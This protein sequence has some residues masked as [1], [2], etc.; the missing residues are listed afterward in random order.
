MKPA[1]PRGARDRGQTEA[2]IVAAVGKVLARDGFAGLGVNAVAREAGVDK[3]LIY[4]YFGGLPELIRA[5]GASGSFW[6]PVRELMGEDPEA[7][8]E[9]PLAE[10]YAGFMENLIDALRARPLTLEILA[11]ELIERKALSGILE[12]ER[13]AWGAQARQVLGGKAFARRHAFHGMTLLL[14]G[15]IQYLLLRSRGTRF[16][17]GVDVRSDKGWAR[18][19]ASVREAAM[20]LLG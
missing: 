18:L 5:W 11:A 17:D 15:G 9:L 16:F 8:L 2:R 1:T 6:P 13:E 7:F 4:R 12:A 10:R 3:V 14:V 20:V 19:K